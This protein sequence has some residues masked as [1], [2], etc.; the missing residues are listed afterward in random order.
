MIAGG[1]VKAVAQRSGRPRR[2]GLRQARCCSRR[3]TH[4]ASGGEGVEIGSGFAGTRL[5]GLAHNDPFVVGDGGRIRTTTNNSGGIQGGISNGEDIT[6]R[7]A[8][9]PT[10]TISSEQQT[11]TRHEDTTLLLVAAMTRVLPRAVPMVES[12]M[13]LTL[14]DHRPRQQQP[15]SRRRSPSAPRPQPTGGRCMSINLAASNV[16]RDRRTVGQRSIEE[17]KRDSLFAD[18]EKFPLEISP[19]GSPSSSTDWPHAEGGGR[20]RR[21]RGSRRGYRGD[22]GRKCGPPRNSPFR[23]ARPTSGPP[24]QW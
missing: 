18:G 13:L 4:V 2:T 16:D 7:I 24:A 14:V 11:V 3:R 19:I 20:R 23:D 1:V 10:G 17:G 21:D 8:F 15:T 22:L 9:K 6:A 12:M 5:S